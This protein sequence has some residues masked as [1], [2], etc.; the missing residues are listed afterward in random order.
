MAKPSVTIATYRPKEGQEE[1]VLALLKRHWPTLRESGLV[2]DEPA[3]LFRA[4]EKKTGRPYFIEIFSWHDEKASS[5]AHKK[6]PVM[7]IWEPMAT[8]IETGRGPELTLAEPL[9]LDG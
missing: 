1:A 7:A 9:G 3:L 5:A 2:T 8:L 4:V 6:K